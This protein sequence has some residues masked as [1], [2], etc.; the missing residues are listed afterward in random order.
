V[1]IGEQEIKEKL[2]W[3]S[4]QNKDIQAEVFDQ[5]LGEQGPQ[6]REALAMA[7]K[8]ILQKMQRDKRKALDR[9]SAV[10]ELSET[11]KLRIK[12]LHKDRKGRRKS[13]LYKR[14]KLR[15]KLIE[16][17]RREG[18]GWRMISLYLQKYSDLTISYQQLRR[19]YIQIKEE[20]TTK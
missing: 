12:A 16:Q 1:R 19:L 14:V 6:V 20:E 17:L 15:L 11:H 18:L 7:A 3:L 5:A 9:E 4:R 13:K 2:R 10:K 8:T